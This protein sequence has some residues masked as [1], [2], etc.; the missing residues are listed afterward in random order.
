MT[1][2]GPRTSLCNKSEA[3]SRLEQAKAFLYVATLTMESH[4][5]R[6]TPGVAAALA[7]L[8]GIAATDAACCAKLG[9]RS[10][11]QDH[12]QACMLVKTV[13]PGGEVMAKALD[14]LLSAK[15]DSH[16]GS[17]LVTGAKAEKMLGRARQLVEFAEQTLRD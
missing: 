3:T 2:P 1:R 5:E 7:V 9:K 15:D 6:A 16:Y 14:Q 17:T 4:D 11:G 12:R 10:R 8:A 13:S